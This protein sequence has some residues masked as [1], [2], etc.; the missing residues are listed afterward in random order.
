M[1]AVSG[2]RSLAGPFD[3]S[4]GTSHV[5][6]RGIHP[7]QSRHDGSGGGS[8]QQSWIASTVASAT[9]SGR[10]S[11]VMLRVNWRRCLNHPQPDSRG[12]GAIEGAERRSHIFTGGHG[13][14]GGSTRPAPTGAN[15]S[16][17]MTGGAQQ[18]AT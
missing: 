4:T 7:G 18:Q 17:S 14:I 8:A 1:L 9:R 12:H 3:E 16:M 6:S 10:D 11:Q 2:R 13:S 15:V 5:D